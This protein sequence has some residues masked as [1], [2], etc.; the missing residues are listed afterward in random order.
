MNGEGEPGP[1]YLADKR[2][3]YFRNSSGFA[4]QVKPSW[5]SLAF[6]TISVKKLPDTK[7]PYQINYTSRQKRSTGAGVSYGTSDYFYDLIKEA[8]KHGILDKGY[9]P[10]F[11]KFDAST[12][13]YL[14]ELDMVYGEFGKMHELL[15]VH[16]RYF[17]AE[18]FQG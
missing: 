18:Q 3:V 12:A 16:V 7:R 4:F 2:K 13:Q 9:T 5:L 14:S 6:E 17:S 10:L 11:H 8:G 15:R 1:L